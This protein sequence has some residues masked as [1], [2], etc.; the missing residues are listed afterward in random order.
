MKNWEIYKKK[1]SLK[2]I[3]IKRAKIKDLIREFFKKEGF[4]EAETPILVKH[5][6]MEPYLSPISLKFKDDKGNLYKGFL[7]TSP[8]YSLK[9]M[10]ASGYEKIFEIT[11]AF[12]QEESFGGLH[13]PEFT[14]LE[15][16]RTQANYL[17]IM[18]DTER[19]I[20]FLTKKLYKKECFFYQ[21]IKIDVSLPFKRM[22]L[23]EAF[24]KYSGIDLNKTKSLKY[25]AEKVKEKGYKLKKDYDQNDL[26]YLIF[27]NEIEPS[28]KKE[29]PIFLYDYPIYQGALAKRKKTDPFYVERFE[30]FIGGIEIANAFSELLDYKEQYQRLKEEQNLRKKL[31]KEYIEIDKDFI[32]ALKSNIPETGGIALGVDRLEMLLLN[33]KDINDLLMFPA[34]QLFL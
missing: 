17:D 23:K 8:E 10:L 1:P 9:K 31:K 33:I 28:L 27:L 15:W 22:S 7:I 32:N 12:R 2:E 18:E 26:F 24:L 20:N 25:F 30:L 16:Y 5:A 34:S 21:G 14:I 3:Q 6:G 13:N 4:L 11:K 29:K 19:L